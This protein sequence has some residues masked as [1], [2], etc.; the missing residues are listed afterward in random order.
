MLCTAT[1]WIL[2]WTTLI[3]FFPMLLA[4]LAFAVAA[5]FVSLASA[6][7]EADLVTL[8]RTIGTIDFKHYAGHLQLETKEK[9]VAPSAFFFCLQFM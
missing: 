5:V 2:R 8:P 1:L 7:H 4:A 3:A 9:C 6:K